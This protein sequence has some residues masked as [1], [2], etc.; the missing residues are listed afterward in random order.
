M[1]GGMREDELWG[2]YLVRSEATLVPIAS[3]I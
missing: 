1:R 3:Q 2:I